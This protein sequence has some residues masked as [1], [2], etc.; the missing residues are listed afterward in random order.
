MHEPALQ[1]HSKAI[2]M[3]GRALA[4]VITDMKTEIPAES[5]QLLEDYH[6]AVVLHLKAL[7]A[8]GA[9]NGDKTPSQAQLLDK[10]SE[11]KALVNVRSDTSQQA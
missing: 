2:T 9:Q 7:S 10:L 6:Q 3:P 11:L 4:G 8:D 5:Y 1:V